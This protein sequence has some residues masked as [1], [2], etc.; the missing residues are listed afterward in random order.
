M[1]NILMTIILNTEVVDI[2]KMDYYNNKFNVAHHG[3]KEVAGWI[4]DQETRFWLLAYRRPMRAVWYG[5][6]V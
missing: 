2:L 1:I 3:G 4:V 5:K 6:K